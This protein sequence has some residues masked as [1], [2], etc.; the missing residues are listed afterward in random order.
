[1]DLIL[2]GGRVIDP[3]QGLDGI[4]DVGFTGG[5]VAAI[6]E[7]LSAGTAE[8]RQNSSASMPSDVPPQ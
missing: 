1:M 2:K 3:S 7:N 5:R 4:R 8:V 6:G